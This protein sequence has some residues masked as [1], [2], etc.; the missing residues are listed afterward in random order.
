MRKILVSITTTRH[1]DWP[2]K[3]KEINKF[4][5]K[6]V[7]LFPTCLDKKERKELY[8]MLEKSVIKSIPLVH[9]RD[10]MVLKELDF[11]VERFKTQAFNIHPRAEYP[12]KESDYGKYR[13]MIFI[14]NVYLPLDEEEIKRMGGVCLD[15]THL[16]ND[17]IVQP[18]KFEHN[19]RIIEKYPI[20]CNHLSCFEKKSHQDQLGY[21]RYDRHSLRK[22]NQMDY[23]KKYPK[24]YFSP[25]VAIELSNTIEKQLEIRDYLMNKIIK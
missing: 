7:A 13:K 11:L 21:L 8:E 24:K 23:L 19:L 5:L 14:E 18:G 4:G 25:F 22:L 12:Y 2:A 10:D 3:I 9:L 16:E 15:F 6:E 20:G 1:S 17:R